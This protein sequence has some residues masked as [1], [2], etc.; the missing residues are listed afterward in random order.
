MSSAQDKSK[1]WRQQ[2]E[3]GVKGREGQARQAESRSAFGNAGVAARA[4]R[5]A[6][7]ASAPAPAVDGSASAG[8]ATSAAAAGTSHAAATAGGDQAPGAPRVVVV[9][10]YRRPSIPYS[11]A[12][13]IALGVSC[14][15]D[16]LYWRAG[17][18]LSCACRAGCC[19]GQGAGCG[20]STRS[21]RQPAPCPQQ[22]PALPPQGPRVPLQPL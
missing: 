19:C 18:C 12:P 8:S 16:L 3:A 5:K 10:V 15:F 4:A 6:A 2:S 21:W 22:Q 14:D 7:E 17:G 20:H 13:R 11:I 1:S 9:V